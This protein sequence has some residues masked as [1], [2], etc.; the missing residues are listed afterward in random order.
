MKIT[1]NEAIKE[2]EVVLVPIF[3]KEVVQDDIGQFNDQ[4][5]ELFEA[6]IFE[7]KKGQTHFLRNSRSYLLVGL[8]DKT[9]IRDDEIRRYFGSAV[10]QVRKMGFRR[11]ALMCFNPSKI[12]MVVESVILAAYGFDKYKSESKEGFECLNIIREGAMDREE[13][14]R[15]VALAEAT[16]LA[17]DLSNEPANVLTPVELAE[18]TKTLG[19][20]YGFEVEVLDESGIEEAGMEA[21][22]AVSSASNQPPR[23]IIMRYRGAD[24]SSEHFGFVGKGLT[25]DAGGLSIKPTSSMVTMKDDMSGASAVIGL[26]VA[27]ARTGIAA[28]VTAVVAACENLISGRGY[29]PGDIIGSRGGKS[30]FIANTDAEGRLTLVDAVDWIQT[31]EQVDS[32]VDI[33]TLTGAAV[34]CLGRTT[35][36]VCTNDQDRFETLRE[37]ALL[38]DERV[39]QMPIYDDYRKQIEHHEADLKNV[40]GK[41]GMITAA[42]FIEAFVTDKPWIHIDIAGTS[43][44]EKAEGYLTEGAT[45]VGVRMLYHYLRA[46]TG[47]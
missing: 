22:L 39:W 30:I 41:P 44:A 2:K 16:L 36:A 8:E 27:C 14:E 37:A 12:A 47:E 45:G 31:E 28:N 33:A 32:I 42:A 23:L 17:R 6:G 13:I 19:E 18:R 9:T 7:G 11:L 46:R 10:R 26:M 5:K 24:E 1:Y 15:H 20:T 3:E 34:H 29:K 38:A 35:S 40:G 4:L 43:W 21:F 25:Y